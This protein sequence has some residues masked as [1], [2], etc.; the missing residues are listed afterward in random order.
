MKN[1]TMEKNRD[2]WSGWL[3][4]VWWLAALGILSAI[5]LIYYAGFTDVISKDAYGQLEIVKKPNFS[6]WAIALLLAGS[7]TMLS[8]IT[9]M[10]N[11][12]Y[13]NSCDF[14]ALQK[15]YASKKKSAYENENAMGVTITA[16]PENSPLYQ[17][18]KPG[19]RL[20]SVNEKL[21]NTI[22]EAES[23]T[24]DGTNEIVFYDKTLLQKNRRVLL[25]E[26]RLYVGTTPM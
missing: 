1:Q 25:K 3:T 24:L 9:C 13:Q 7:T 11:S 21:V 15:D 4:L 17:I 14:I 12:I 5:T 18:V 2:R 23:A 26:R 16:V 19:D 6:A 20:V 22:K 8:V 10:V